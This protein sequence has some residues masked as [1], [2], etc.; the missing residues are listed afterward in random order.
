[1]IGNLL[2]SPINL[3]AAR[4]APLAAAHRLTART[5]HAPRY[6]RAMNP[7]RKP[8]PADVGDEDR[9]LVTL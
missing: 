9:V 3:P 5:R 2:S 7:L 6:S 8:Y 4:R 1:M